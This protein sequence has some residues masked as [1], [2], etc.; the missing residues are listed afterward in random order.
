MYSFLEFF[1]TNLIFSSHITD[2]RNKTNIVKS[3]KPVLAMTNFRGLREFR[4]FVG[5]SLHDALV[6]GFRNKTY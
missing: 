3:L 1:R 5:M 4:L 6:F 2:A